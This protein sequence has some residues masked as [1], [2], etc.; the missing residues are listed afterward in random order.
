MTSVSVDLSVK[1]SDLS[2]RLA[3][4]NLNRAMSDSIVDVLKLAQQAVIAHAV[5]VF[6][7][8]RRSF[9]NQSIKITEFPKATKLVGEIG[10]RNPN[11]APADRA[12]VLGKFEIGGTKR[13]RAEGLIAV[14]ITGSP[15][16]PKARSII[17]PQF[18][19]VAL[20]LGTRQGQALP[21]PLLRVFVRNTARGKVI[22]GQVRARNRKG[23]GPKLPRGGGLTEVRPLYLLIKSAEIDDRLEFRPRVTAVVRAEWVPAFNRRW[24]AAVDKA[25]LKRFK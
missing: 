15:V 11:S 12:N 14:P 16:K 8:R 21:P 18:R 22:F 10:V 19:P 7:I 25:V 2:L 1:V 6:T 4:K 5:S 13:S 3:G 9:L 17:K 23:V 24:N 20:L